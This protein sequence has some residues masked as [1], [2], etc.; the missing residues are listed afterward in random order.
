MPDEPTATTTAPPETL[1]L[2]R[3]ALDAFRARVEAQR[4]A[5]ADPEV[6]S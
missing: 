3:A 5:L 2:T 1:T 4:Q 6:K